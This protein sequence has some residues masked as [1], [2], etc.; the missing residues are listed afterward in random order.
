M[1]LGDRI[2]HRPNELSGGQKQRVAIARALANEPSIILADE[3]TG[4]LD[5]RTGAEIMSLFGRLHGNG[6]TIV[7]VT[8]EEHVAAYSRRVVRFRDGLVESDG[9]RGYGSMKRLLRGR[10]GKLAAAVAVAAAGAM[11]A[12]SRTGTGENE[13]AETFVVERGEFR[14][15]HFEAGEIR[16]RKDEKILAPEV[17]GRLKITYLWPEG[18]KVE[19]G[20]LNPR[21]RPRRARGRGQERGR[22]AGESTGR[23]GKGTG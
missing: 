9:R 20:D 21:L 5:T 23:P 6:H 22:R 7:V 18:E 13:A 15:S 19:I 1:G 17:R 4:A 8:H 10:R 14:I 16:A 12:L 3:P 2:H 11:L